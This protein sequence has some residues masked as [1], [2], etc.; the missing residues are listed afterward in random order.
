MSEEVKWIMFPGK[1][2]DDTACSKAVKILDQAESGSKIR[3]LIN[4]KEVEICHAR[5]LYE[6]IKRSKATTQGV[7]KEHCD[8]LGLVILQACDKRVIS[9][10]SKVH[11]KIKNNGEYNRP[12][13]MLAWETE[14]SDGVRLGEI[15]AHRC[16]TTRFSLREIIHTYKK[17]Y[18]GI[19]EV[20]QYNLADRTE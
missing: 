17:E 11:L 20:I 16:D 1:K 13:A 5:S 10:Y 3:I 2:I 19:S 12:E 7:I 4:R 8:L 15:L 9:K 14:I 6:A 18:F